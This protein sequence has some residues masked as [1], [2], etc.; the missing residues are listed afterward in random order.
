MPSRAA[1]SAGDSEGGCVADRGNVD[2]EA[3]DWSPGVRRDSAAGRR[4]G[5]RQVPGADVV[6]SQRLS[7]ATPD[8]AILHR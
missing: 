6:E 2:L 8:R 4:V 1:V 5:L 7:L 3:R